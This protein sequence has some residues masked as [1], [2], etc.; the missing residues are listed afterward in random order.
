[1]CI[2]DRDDTDL[3]KRVLENLIRCGAFD[4]FGI[5][6]S[7]LLDA[8]GQVVDSIAQTR[9]KN[10]EGQFDLFGGGET[11]SAAP[12]MVLKN[13]LLYTSRCV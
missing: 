5:F 2:R 6:R 4:S 12:A 7:Q 11:A 13:C 9:K 3:N 1:M 10:L 8:Y